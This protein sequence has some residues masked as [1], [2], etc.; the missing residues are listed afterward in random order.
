[1]CVCVCLYKN[2][3]DDPINKSSLTCV[4][5]YPWEV[6]G[7]CIWRNFYKCHI[8]RGAPN[9]VVWIYDTADNNLE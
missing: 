6:S 3:E 4:V 8:I 2:E 1:M 7:K 9:I 5:L